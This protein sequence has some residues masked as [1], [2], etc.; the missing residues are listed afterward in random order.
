[1]PL[2]LDMLLSLLRCPK[3]KTPLVHDGEALVCA[4]PICRL[5]FAIKEEIPIML[6]DEATELPV[7]DWGEIMRRNG[8]DSGTG[9]PVEENRQ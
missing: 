8:R 5:R 7:E 9:Q 2:S 6:L 3:S 1:M 4:D